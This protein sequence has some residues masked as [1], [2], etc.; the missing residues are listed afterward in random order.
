MRVIGI[1]AEYNPFHNGH[2]YLI[3]KAREIVNDPRAIV[4]VVMSGAFTERGEVSL[5]P[6]HVR[7]QMA[8]ECGADLV[9]E[10]PFSFACAP[11]G[12]FSAGAIELLYRT[13]VVTDIAFGIDS[14]DTGLIK[15]LSELDLND[16]LYNERLSSN[17]ESGMSFP[18][19]RAKAICDSFDFDCPKE[20]VADTLHNSNTI[21]AIDYLRNISKYKKP[22]NVHM[23]PRIGENYNSEELTE[24]AS[25]TAIRKVIYECKNTAEMMQK[26]KGK[27]P[28]NALSV[29]LAYLNSENGSLPDLNLYSKY[30]INL[31]AR[32]GDISRYAYLNDGL[33]GYITN[34]TNKLRSDETDYDVYM[35]KLTTK[36]F[37]VPRVN[38]ALAS[39]AMGQTAS[40]IEEISHIPYIRVLGFNRDGKYCLKVMGKAADIPVI[41]NCSDFWELRVDDKMKRLFE[42]DILATNLRSMLI[43]EEL[44][45]CW[46]TPP[47]YLK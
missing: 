35:S 47:L 7:A 37:T 19:A 42:L 34:I 43:G 16:T 24:F 20:K 29:M 46:K 2:E 12:R 25:A 40:F 39:M 44:N 41:H 4:M 23:I 36:H 8:L 1:V 32:D 11:S 18:S 9:L 14:D 45:R 17:I 27:M 26:L 10:L 33:S 30:L 21:L 3:K 22:V 38:R 31:I 15:Q 6:K 5:L 28:D 13:G